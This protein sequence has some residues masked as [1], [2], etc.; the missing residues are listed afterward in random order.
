MTAIDEIIL[1]A[2]T[3]VSCSQLPHCRIPAA[4]IR[5]ISNMSGH[6]QSHR[7]LYFNGIQLLCAFSKSCWAWIGQPPACIRV[8]NLHVDVK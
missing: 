8:N 3:G 1:W 6:Y 7:E 5:V 4:G 2:A